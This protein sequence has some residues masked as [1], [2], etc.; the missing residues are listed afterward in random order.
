MSASM[1]K[2]NVKAE[3]LNGFKDICI[4]IYRNLTPQS[5]L[6]RHA[7][8]MGIVLSVGCVLIYIF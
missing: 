2:A 1:E 4:K 3:R 7:V 5:A 8:R 6:F